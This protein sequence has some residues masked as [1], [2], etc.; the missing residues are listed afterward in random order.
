[1][2]AHAVETVWFQKTRLRRHWVET[3]TVVWW[4][5]IAVA[6]HGGGAGIARFGD[7]V[8]EKRRAKELKEK[9]V[10]H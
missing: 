10:Q 7:L 4:L 3:G 5:W 6:L 8:A 1:M 2:V 9:S